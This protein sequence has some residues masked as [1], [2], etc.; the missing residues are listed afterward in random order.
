MAFGSNSNDVEINVKLLTEQAQKAIDDF[1]KGMLDEFKEAAKTVD[2]FD[3]VVKQVEKNLKKIAEEGRKAGADI[4]ISFNSASASVITLNQTLDLVGKSLNAVTRFAQGVVS[5]LE[6]AAKV[7]GIEN[8]FGNLIGS[9]SERILAGLRSATRGLV[10]DFELMQR[11][12]QAVLLGLP[13]DGFDK[14]SASAI[15]L[16]RAMGLDAGAAIESLTLGIGRQS[17]LILDNL[18]VVIDV[19]EA[20]RNFA[21]TNG[22]LGRELNETEKKLAFQQEAYR[23]IEE[24]AEKAG[25]KTNTAAGAFEKIKASLENQANAGAKA[26]SENERLSKSFERLGGAINRSGTASL[27]GDTLSKIATAASDAAFMVVETANGLE[28]L[29]GAANKAKLAFSDFPLFDLGKSVVS[30]LERAIVG[31][32]EK[33]ASTYQNIRKEISDTEK[34]R[35][36]FSEEFSARALGFDRIESFDKGKVTA[37]TGELQKLFKAQLSGAISSEEAAKRLDQYSDTVVLTKKQLEDFQKIAKRT[38]D[39]TKKSVDEATRSGEKASRKAQSELDKQKREFE[40]FE[41]SIR[42]SLDIAIPQRFSDALIQA[43]ARNANSPEKLAEA[44]KQIGIEA[45]DAGVDLSALTREFAE[46]Q[47]LQAEGGYGPGNI[48]GENKARDEKNR[49]Q[50]IREGLSSSAAIFENLFGDGSEA[51]MQ[52]SEQLGG[53][54]QSAIV[55]AFQA[56]TQA[57]E[58]GLGRDDIA[59]LA[60]SIGSA[61]S[62]ALGDSTGASGQIVGTIIGTLAAEMG[63]DTAGTKAR[64]SADAFFADIFDAERLSIVVN[65]EMARLQDLVFRGDTL[66]GGSTDFGSGQFDDAFAQQSAQVQASFNAVGSAFEQLL[67][68][69]DDISGQIAAVLFNNVGESLQNLQ[70]L[71]QTTGRSFED[72]GDAIIQSFFNGNL[73]IQQA[74]DS[75]AQ[76]QQL[77]EVGIPGAIGAVDQAISNFQTALADGRGSRMLIDSLRDIGAEGRE[78]GRSLQS[79]A[80]QVGASLGFS[81][82]QVAQLFEAMR[83]V[84]ISSVQ[85]LAEASTAQ[86]IALAENIRRIRDGV[87]GIVSAPVDPNANITPATNFTPAAPKQAASSK[88]GESAAKRAAEEAKRRREELYKLMTASTQYTKI[89]DALNDKTITQAQAA[90]QIRELYEGIRKATEA[91][92]KAE[93]DYQKAI[94]KGVKGNK[95][96]EALNKLKKAQEELKKLTDSSKEKTP[97]FDASGA[98]KLVQ[99]VNELAVVARAAGVD[100]EALSKTLTEGFLRGRLS[101]TEY[102]NE[103]KKLEE[104]FSDGI[105]GAV[106]DVQQALNNLREGGRNGGIFSIDAFKDIFAEFDELFGSQSSDRRKNQLAQLTDEFN[107]ARDALQNAISGGATPAAIG[108][109]RKQFDGASKALDDFKNSSD[110]AD[111]GD[112]RSELGKFLSEDQLT[113]FFGALEKEGIKSFDEIKNAA[114]SAITG[115]LASLDELGFGFG[116]TSDRVKGILDNL[117]QANIKQTQGKDILGQALDIVKGFNADT[118]AANFGTLG[119]KISDTLSLLSGLGGNTFNNDI[120]FNVKTN[121]EGGALGLVDLLFGDGSGASDGTTG[122]SPGLSPSEQAEFDRLSALRDRRGKLSPRDRRRFQELRRK[123]K[124]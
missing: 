116:E 110:K 19:E 15:K 55:T 29:A 3:K 75:L 60:G 51:S 40:Q 54:L 95:L 27:L 93:T 26:F 118:L 96:I 64:K 79:V 114:P 77:F 76:L 8:A 31:T 61:I 107:A 63:K 46:L 87:A 11:A 32:G 105:P 123:A 104:T 106:G 30:G 120:V 35:S 4:G 42:Q 59:G 6:R 84:G 48:A 113:A 2:G 9:D 89:L 37:I 82:N 124:G 36:K 47:K 25:E 45:R 14:L 85:Q 121:G 98:L 18:G 66:F 91:A 68:V 117:D 62:M 119:D 34:E 57:I 43:F 38:F 103:L 16:G 21:D 50:D 28:K 5:T 56:V 41:Q 78:V 94:E 24:A 99:T 7:E 80:Q 20:Y 74:Y 72:L 101:I 108:E 49:L 100:V 90:R 73:S 33:I 39:Q 13:I 111:F 109:L 83:V 65:G 122:G 17:K 86:L 71:V 92:K 53:A 102:R 81:T 44:I 70:I 12:N 112:L 22:I 115:I 67:G 88:S 69:T 97:A 23:K 10:S 52:L 1:T 58:G